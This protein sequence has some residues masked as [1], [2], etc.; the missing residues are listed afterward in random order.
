MHPPGHT[1]AAAVLRAAIKESAL[2]IYSKTCL[3]RNSIVPGFF[4]RFHSFP[5]YT[6]LCLK[7]ITKVYNEGTI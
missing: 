7:K 3:S 1:A 6:G 5:F 4:F 2:Y